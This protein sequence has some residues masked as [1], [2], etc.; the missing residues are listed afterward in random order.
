M[1]IVGCLLAPWS[2][3][4]DPDR[5]TRHVY[6]PDCIM[7]PPAVSASGLVPDAGMPFRSTDLAAPLHCCRHADDACRIVSNTCPGC[8]PSLVPVGSGFCRL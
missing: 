4:K 1:D 5:Y 6:L 8:V 3:G 7:K 2:S